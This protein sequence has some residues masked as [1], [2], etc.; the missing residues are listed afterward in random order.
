MENQFPFLE[1]LFLEFDT[2][3]NFTSGRTRLS[4]FLS[5][6]TSL[7]KD[8]IKYELKYF[9]N[10]KKLRVFAY[11]QCEEIFNFLKISNKKLKYLE[12]SGM[13]ADEKLITSISNYAKLT[14]LKFNC[15][16]VDEDELN[17]LPTHLTKLMNPTLDTK[18]FDWNS[19]NII[20][21]IE[22]A[23]RLRRLIVTVD[24]KDNQHSRINFKRLYK[25]VDDSCN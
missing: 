6:D 25:A 13:T 18:Y 19:S 12:F 8:D 22:D 14:N 23:K 5:P 20:K 10:L 17:S 3:T 21:S 4:R 11:G 7:I 24:R 1:H 2:E 15:S 9:N 16:Y